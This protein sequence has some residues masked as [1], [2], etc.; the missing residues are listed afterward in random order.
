M[1]V[2]PATPTSGPW[3]EYWYVIAQLNK[4]TDLM[5]VLLYLSYM[6]ITSKR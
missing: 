5:N 4:Y 1:I 3:S 2:S 6:K